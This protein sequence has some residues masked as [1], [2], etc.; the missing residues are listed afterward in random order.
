MY[1]SPKATYSVED[2]RMQCSCSVNQFIRRAKELREYIVSETERLLSPDGKA[3]LGAVSRLELEAGGN[4]E[5]RQRLKRLG[6][7]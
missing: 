6:L 7:L 3:Y 4:G 2:Q 1:R 5:V